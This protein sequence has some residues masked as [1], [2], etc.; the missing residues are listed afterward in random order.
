MIELF[1]AFR[2]GVAGIDPL[3]AF[4]YDVR[5]GQQ[6]FTHEC[7]PADQAVQVPGYSN[8]QPAV[9]VNGQ[10]AGMLAAIL[11]HRSAMPFSFSLNADS[12]FAFWFRHPLD[13]RIY[14]LRLT[15]PVSHLWF[16]CYMLLEDKTM[17]SFPNPCMIPFPVPALKKMQPASPSAV[18]DD[19]FCKKLSLPYPVFQS[20]H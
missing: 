11:V 9:F 15:H 10:V 6:A 20:L 14:A 8:L 2:D 3:C 13:R 16:L 12:F 5:H 19:V 17:R 7:K 18:S 4:A 1:I